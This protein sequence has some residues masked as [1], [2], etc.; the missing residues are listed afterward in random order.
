MQ[1]V[2][3]RLC[4]R[5]R[6]DQQPL[7]PPLTADD[8]AAQIRGPPDSRVV[9]SVRAA[10]DGGGDSVVDRGGSGASARIRFVRLV[11][12]RYSMMKYTSEPP[13]ADSITP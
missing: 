12:A 1:P 11:P 4:T 8:I 5:P 13:V 10:A 7:G 6:V 3:L 9:L 2:E